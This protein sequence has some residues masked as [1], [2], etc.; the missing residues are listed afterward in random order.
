LVCNSSDCVYHVCQKCSFCDTDN[1]ETYEDSKGR[2]YLSTVFIFQPRKIVN[3]PIFRTAEKIMK[4]NLWESVPVIILRWPAVLAQKVS[5]SS[6]LKVLIT[7]KNAKIHSACF[8]VVDQS[9]CGKIIIM[10]AIPHQQQRT[11]HALNAIEN[12]NWP[13]VVWRTTRTIIV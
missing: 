3:I 2:S 1:L 4:W 11:I 7:V 9:F 13:I 12:S 6:R 8:A 5:Y 10:P